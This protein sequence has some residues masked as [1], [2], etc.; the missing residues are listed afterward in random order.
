MK[1]THG[2]FQLSSTPL[3]EDRWSVAVSR[4]DR[5]KIHYQGKEERTVIVRI[6]APSDDQAI[7]EVRQQI[8]KAEIN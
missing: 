1:V 8:D 7:Q 5:G 4:T 2:V 6:D 3:G